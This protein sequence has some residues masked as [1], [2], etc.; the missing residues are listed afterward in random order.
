MIRST[1]RFV[2]RV[3]VVLLSA[4]ALANMC[5]AQSDTARLQG[6]VTDPNDA[7]VAGA[8]VKVTNVGTER[9]V[10]V[11]TDETGFFTVSALPPGHY[12]VTVTL[13]GFK[14][15][16]RELDLQVAQVGVADFKLAVG[17]VTQ[18]V[19]VEA[20]SPVIDSA[21]S[22][23]GE[24]IEGR[25]VTELPLNGRN[26]TQL[27]LLAPGVTRGNPT[28]AATGANNNAETFRFGQS[29]GAALAVNG[30]RPQNDNFILDGIDNNE[31]LVN[32]I[33]FFPPADAIDEFRVQTNLAPAEFGRAGGALVVTSLKSG[34]NDYHG[35]AFWFNRNTSL[36]ARDFFTGPPTPTFD[37]NQ[38]GGTVGG[39]IIKN[40]LFFFGDFE[41]L[42]Q[43]QPAGNDVASV[44]TD[45]MRNGD[46]SQLLNMPC[47][48]A[49]GANVT[50][51]APLPDPA[52]PK[53]NLCQSGQATFS[54]PIYDPT[55]A[56]SQPKTINNPNGETPFP[57]N[58]IPPGR[59]NP[60]GQAY[61]KAFPE[62]NCLTAAV[63]SRCHSL[64]QDYHNVRKLIENWNDFDVRGDYIFNT[65]NSLFVRISRGQADQTDTTR[66]TTLPS[67]FG[68]GTNFNHPWG[69]SIGWTDTLSPVLINEARVGFVR[70]TYGYMAPSSNVA[71]CTQ[72]G[73]VNCDNATNGGIALIGGYNNEIEYTG[74]YGTYLIPQTSYNANDS[75]TWIKGKHTVK[76]GGDIIRRQLNLYRPLAGKGYFAIAGNG[77]SPCCGVAPGQG[78]FS[79]GY[80]VSD[81][82]AGFVDGYAHGTNFGIVGTRSWENGFF[83]QDDYRMS[84]RLTLNLG[85]RYDVLTWPVEVLNRQANFD[86]TTGALVVAGS[87][88]GSRGLI[89]NDYHN[90]GPRLGFAYQLTKDGK[91]V[92]RGGYGL[93][94][95]LDRGGISNQLAQ[96]PPFS[97]TNGVSYTQGARVTLSGSLPCSN[98]T[99]GCTTAQLNS[100]LATGPLPSGNFTNLNLAA[101][102][103]VSV[104]AVLPTN[105]TPMV[106][107]WNLQVQHQLGNNSSVSLAYVGTHGARL[108]RNYDANQQ[109]FG[110]PSG[111]KLF[112]NLGSITTQDNSGKSDYHSLQAQY[113]RRLTNGLN[114]TGAFTWSKT[115][116]DSCG[117]LDTCAPQFYKNFGIERGLSNQDQPYRLVLSSLYELPFG[118]GKR[119][120][121]DVSRALDYAVGGWQLN[122]IYVLQAGLPF[123]ITVNGNPGNT[124]ADLVGKP[125]VQ[126]GNLLQ[127]VTASAFAIPASTGG[128]FNAPGTS[129]RDILRGPG[130]S[131]MDLSLF[132]NFSFTEQI[133]A[134][135]RVQ[136]YNLTNTPHFANPNS[137]LSNGNFGQITST[138]PFS[139]RQVELG[140]RVTF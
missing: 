36:N 83:T 13:K 124:R 91:N 98:T 105:L 56:G 11:A 108:T 107:Q 139:Y 102:T 40:K 123:S 29:G 134:Q 111:T 109:L 7:A 26:F 24:V 77:T 112:P 138:Q 87:N 66:L 35:S 50:G 96:N 73:I 43:K 6:T 140:L 86:L 51:E 71:L 65:T 69:T 18:S 100:T 97:G 44:P 127:Y 10:S 114:F 55:T 126:P 72:L 60:V 81:L 70:T 101:P 120:G 119:W 2:G 62:P 94:Y 25:Q 131:N 74:D 103:G 92:V 22:A 4:L 122:G 38:F 88:G 53:I 95:F 137:D 106:S 85:L 58:I 48:S 9:E 46:F 125:V 130:S 136:A 52:N 90:F 61:L 84:P 75:L 23:I 54:I 49:S 16:V 57:G 68:S 33:V 118:R 121:H 64:L 47:P 89:P 99:A 110:M 82:L 67:G 80:E 133:K 37:R 128:V 3:T 135:F 34:T 17:E 1:L 31:T 45:Q 12:R 115:I 78:S 32:T 14:E 21:D 76:F 19:V 63:D 129:G 30:L 28:G 42:R 79:T 117:D 5:Y 132:K 59:L 116:D 93:F 39:P 8:T 27:A 104:I 113:E 20:G 15:T 41:G